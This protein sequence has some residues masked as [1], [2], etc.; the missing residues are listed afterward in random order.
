VYTVRAYDSVIGGECFATDEAFIQI[1]E[2]PQP[3]FDI[4]DQVCFSDGDVASHVYAPL[5]NSPMYDLAVSR[6]WAITSGNATV[7][8]TG[9]VTITGIGTVEVCMTE[10]IETPACAGVINLL[11]VD[12]PVSCSE[13][14]CVQ[15]E[16]SDGTAQDAS[17]DI[18]SQDQCPGAM[19]MLNANT[20]GGEF[21][22]DGVVDNGDG[23]SG[24]V[25]IPADCSSVDVTYTLNDPNGC[26]SSATQTVFGDRIDPVIVST[27]VEDLLLECNNPTA[28][29][30]ALIEAWLMD[31]AGATATDNCNFTW[32]YDLIAESDDCSATGSGTYRFTVTDECGNS[33][34]FDASIII[35]DTTDPEITVPADLS[36]SCM[37][38]ET[39]EQTVEGWL[40][41]A[42]ATDD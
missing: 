26:T 16:V 2:E 9:E 8:P 4:Q 24:S 32:S 10:T 15:I 5:I 18:I 12:T 29:N 42:T 11:L 14:F 17:F 21:S 39:I 34:F 1:P 37:N 38:F 25:I 35:N 33:S 40:N 30:D 3:S 6:T 22:G 41:Q 7:A 23:M 36:I 19:I 31:N 13:T 27:G 28:D 20:F